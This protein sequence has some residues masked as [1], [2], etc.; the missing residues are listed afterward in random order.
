MLVRLWFQGCIL[1]V[2]W[3]PLHVTWATAKH[4]VHE[5]LWE[6]TTGGQGYGKTQKDTGWDI[7]FWR[8]NKVTELIPWFS[9]PRHSTLCCEPTPEALDRHPGDHLALMASQIW[10]TGARAPSPQL[11][12]PKSCRDRL[13]S[14]AQNSCCLLSC[15][16]TGCAAPS[17]PDRQLLTALPHTPPWAQLSPAGT[18]GTLQGLRGQ[19]WDTA[20]KVSR[21][22]SRKRMH[23]Q[24]RI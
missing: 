18:P 16:G 3:D 8:K 17:V 23:S 4:C 11:V 7:S 22:G 24:R 1:A 21:V 19:V 2:S 6:V 14:T 20:W 10:S 12:S 5:S 13:Q 15:L 9:Q